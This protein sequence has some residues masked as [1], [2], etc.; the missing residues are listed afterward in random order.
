MKP[1]TNYARKMNN[2]KAEVSPTKPVNY[3]TAN[4]ERMAKRKKQDR[5]LVGIMALLVG[6]LIVLTGQALANDTKQA[7]APLTKEAEVKVAVAGV[8]KMEEASIYNPDIPMPKEHQEYLYELCQERGLDYVKTLAVIQHESAF[9][10]NAT[11][12]TNDFGYF[13]VNQVNHSTLAEKLDTV[14]DPFNPY[15]NM[16][17][18]TYMLSDLYTFWSERGY[19]GQ[20]LDD[21]VWSSYNKGRNGFILNGHAVSYINKMKASIE[22]INEKF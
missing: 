1:T 11:N 10:P 8:Q 22:N 3:V 15:I 21:A 6:L 16:D 20:G 17:W 7:E 19:H 18:G 13:Q 12:A 5:L 14:N 9:N 2:Q 4:P